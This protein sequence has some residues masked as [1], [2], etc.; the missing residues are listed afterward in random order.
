MHNGF[1][2]QEAMDVLKDETNCAVFDEIRER[3]ASGEPLPSF[4]HLYCPMRY[5][6][7]FEG[8]ILYLPFLESLSISVK[9]TDEET[10]RKKELAQGIVY[11][12]LLLGG[13]FLSMWLFS[14]F[15]LPRMVSLLRVFNSGV[16]QYETL[17]SVMRILFPILLI[18]L[19]LCMIAC[20]LALTP[21]RIASTYRLLS[22]TLPDSL[23][24]QYASVE[25]VRFYIEFLRAGTSTIDAMGILKNMQGKPLTSL[26]ASELDDMFMGGEAFV[27][28]V[29][30]HFI[31]KRLT[32]FLRIALYSSD[33]ATMLEG[34]LE[35]ASERTKAMIQRFSRIAQLIS[36]SAVGIVLVIVYQILMAPMS[37]LQNI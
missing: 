22:Q 2:L 25:F 8:F 31:E 1:S 27:E 11:P 20:A 14:L 13:M 12:L 9:I 17:A 10:Q 19:T 34:Y 30:S 21:S 28:A 6:S 3:L 35:M 24:C 4:F 37:I 16:S 7:Y 29:D 32:K 26:I 36:Y 5:R 15:I 33:C 18:A 23:L